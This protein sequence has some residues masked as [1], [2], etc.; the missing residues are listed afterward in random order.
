MHGSELV[1]PALS[2][3][4]ETLLIPLYNRQMESRT[5]SHVIRRMV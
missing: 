4:A 5:D 1:D 3:V 2:D